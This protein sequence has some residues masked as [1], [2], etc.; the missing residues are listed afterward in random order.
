MSEEWGAESCD[1]DEATVESVGFEVAHDSRGLTVVTLRYPNGA[2]TSLPLDGS[3]IGRLV[4]EPGLESIRE[5][6]GYVFLPSRRSGPR[7]D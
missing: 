2:R 1:L 6:V 7:T 5:R 4:R 3:A